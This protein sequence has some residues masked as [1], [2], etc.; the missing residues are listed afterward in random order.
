[1]DVVGNGELLVL[2]NNALKYVTSQNMHFTHKSNGKDGGCCCNTM[3]YPSRRE[4]KPRFCFVSKQDIRLSVVQLRA[5]LQAF[6]TNHKNK[7][8]TTK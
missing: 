3:L 7:P 6:D 8:Q 5:T 4:T 1:M 2:R